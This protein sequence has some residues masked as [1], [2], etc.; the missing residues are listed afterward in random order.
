MPF[1][2]FGT[3][4]G[5]FA[6]HF[7]GEHDQVIHLCHNSGSLLQLDYALFFLPHFC[8]GEVLLWKGIDSFLPVFEAL[9]IV[10]K[11]L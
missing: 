11:A 2:C 6:L 4:P 8:R 10:L 7:P 9:L 5:H 1:Q 3:I